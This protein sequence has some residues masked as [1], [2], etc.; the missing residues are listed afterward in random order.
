[1]GYLRA[2]L[3]F[4]LLGLLAG[5]HSSRSSPLPAA[6]P[7]K[8]HA[9]AA[10][11]HAQN[12]K[13]KTFTDSPAGISFDYPANWS[14]GN[15][16]TAV[17]KAD[18]PDHAASLSLN[19]PNLPFHLPGMI[20]SSEVADGYIKDMKKRLGGAKVEQNEKVSIPKG[21]AR[22]VKITGSKSGKAST[23]RA[24]LIVHADKVYILS[25][26]AS[27]SGDKPAADALNGAVRTLK[28]H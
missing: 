15:D 4:G 9:T 14:K 12:A 16:K 11:G 26:D 25:S 19:V 23:D 18:S 3:G 8:P 7:P 21:S 17:F 28:W 10:N 6:A 13:T 24:V 2:T 5:C 1:M 27:G 22:R 20:T